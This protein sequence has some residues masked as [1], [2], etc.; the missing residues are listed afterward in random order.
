M[1]GGGSGQLVVYC[2]RQRK[3][4]EEVS[5]AHGSRSVVAIE[6]DPARPYSFATAST[7]GSVKFWSL[8][9]DETT[10]AAAPSSSVLFR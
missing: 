4:V 2:L 9:P 3:V 5:S 1:A 7:D 10:P 8:L 6:G